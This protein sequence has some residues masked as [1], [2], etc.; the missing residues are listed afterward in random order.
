M[1]KAA[2]TMIAFLSGAAIGAGVG[3]L[4]APEK[5]VDTRRRLSDGANSAS[6]KAKE[7]WTETSA[8]I[9]AKTKKTL[10]EFEEKLDETLSAASYKADDI[11]VSLQQKL[12]ELREQNKKLQKA[13]R[14]VEKTPSSVASKA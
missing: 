8:E 2:N 5:G 1:S 14:S 4:Y 7:K 10:A 9:N 12:D 6:K 11:I 13:K 3:L